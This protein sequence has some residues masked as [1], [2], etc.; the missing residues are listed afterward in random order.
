[1]DDAEDVDEGSGHKRKPYLMK[2]IEPLSD[3]EVVD[4]KKLFNVEESW[5]TL[6]N[7]PTCMR[8]MIT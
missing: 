5:H 3:E 6:L 2:F 4:E 8:V 1:M 7:L